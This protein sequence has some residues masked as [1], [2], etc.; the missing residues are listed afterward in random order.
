M[1]LRLQICH[2][3]VDGLAQLLLARYDARD[4]LVQLVDVDLLTGVLLL[5]PRG[6][7]EVVLVFSDRKSVV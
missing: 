2:D 4:A 3:D 1:P 5:H 7:A 6:D